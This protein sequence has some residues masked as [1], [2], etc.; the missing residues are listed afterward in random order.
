MRPR[1]SRAAARL[2]TLVIALAATAA[3]CAAAGQAAP[4]VPPV[5]F[6]IDG[7][8]VTFSDTTQVGPFGLDGSPASIGF[9]TLK[10]TTTGTFLIVDASGTTTHT[11]A[12]G[13]CRRA[14][15]GGPGGAFLC[16]AA[17]GSTSAPDVVTGSAAVAEYLKSPGT[18][19]AVFVQGD[20]NGPQPAQAAAGTTPAGSFYC[21][22]PASAKPMTGADGTQLLADTNGW[23]YAAV[24]ANEE[25]VGHPAYAA[26]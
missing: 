10:A 2:S 20:P 16:G 9:L 4:I 19:Y 23:L 6:C 14:L 12:L 5:S 15:V 1:F 21:V 3:L 22:P 18:H 8:T 11:V 25:T 26:G 13:A 17:Y 7:G 24:F